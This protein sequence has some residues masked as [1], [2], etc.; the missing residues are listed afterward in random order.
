MF[1]F[2]SLMRQL[3]SLVDRNFIVKSFVSDR[4]FLIMK[5]TFAMLPLIIPDNS[6]ESYYETGH[7]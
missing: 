7:S 3:L 5:Q 1:R 4:C 6:S 2:L